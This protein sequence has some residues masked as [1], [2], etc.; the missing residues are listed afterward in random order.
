MKNVYRSFP[1]MSNEECTV[2]KMFIIA[3]IVSDC[4]NHNE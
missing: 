4:W 3:R 2:F 1:R